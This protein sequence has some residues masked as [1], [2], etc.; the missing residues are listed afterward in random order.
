MEKTSITSEISNE[1][2]RAIGLLRNKIPVEYDDEFFKGIMLDITNLIIV[3]NNIALEAAN[4][5]D[6]LSEKVSLH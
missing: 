5:S 6:E 4:L 1:V 3:L 2:S